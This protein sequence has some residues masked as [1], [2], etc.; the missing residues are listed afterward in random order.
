LD[1]WLDS[2]SRLVKEVTTW[3]ELRGWSIHQD[4]KQI[5]EADLG[6]Y[7]VPWLRISTPDGE[8]HL[9]PIAR[10]VTG[11]AE[12]RVDLQA[13]PSLNR[14]MLLRSP[15]GWIIMTDS[16]VPIREQWNE[17]TFARL[18]KDLLSR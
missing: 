9:E 15:S 16:G 1:D 13:W 5:R 18:A 11:E 4:Q 12:G 2:M 7:Q 17:Q 14:V 8:I 6:I 10:Y 3:A